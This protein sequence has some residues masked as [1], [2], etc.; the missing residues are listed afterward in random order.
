MSTSNAI[1]TKGLV[2]TSSVHRPSSRLPSRLPKH[3][4]LSSVAELDRK[5]ENTSWL[6]PKGDNSRRTVNAQG[7]TSSKITDGTTVRRR[8][9]SASGHV[10]AQK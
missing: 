1:G 5:D 2:R 8:G 6:S 9:V 10:K 4:T 7:R 3:A